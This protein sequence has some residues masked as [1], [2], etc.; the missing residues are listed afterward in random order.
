[1][2]YRTKD[3][4]LG[5]SQVAEKSRA[6]SS[7]I[8]QMNKRAPNRNVPEAKVTPMSPTHRESRLTGWAGAGAGGDAEE[9]ELVS[10]MPEFLIDT[11][12]RTA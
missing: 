10:L 12:S 11:T 1:M 9:W 4:G 8:G 6:W 3:L 2:A 7:G 5:P